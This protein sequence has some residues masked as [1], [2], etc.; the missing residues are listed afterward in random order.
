M[1]NPDAAAPAT[2]EIARADLIPW[3]REEL[4]VGPEAGV[5]EFRRTLLERLEKESWFPS[6]EAQYALETLALRSAEE[7]RAL[8]GV[9]GGSFFWAAEKKLRE[10]VERFAEGF[11]QQSPPQRTI[12]WQ[13]L[14]ERCRTFPTLA[15]RL[16]ALQPG[17]EVVVP[18]TGHDRAVLDLAEHLTQLF[19]LRP[20]ERS[21]RRRTP[22]ERLTA[23]LPQ[24]RDA[25]G[26]LQRQLPLV[27]ALEPGLVNALL[28][29]KKR[30]VSRLGELVP[31]FDTD[32]SARAHDYGGPKKSRKIFNLAPG[33]GVA[34]LRNG[35]VIVVAMFAI[36]VYL[37][38]LSSSKSPPA[39]ST[40][41]AQQSPGAYGRVERDLNAIDREP[42]NRKVAEAL[43]RL[44]AQQQAPRPA[45]FVPRS[46]PMPNPVPNPNRS[47][48]PSFNRPSSRPNPGPAIPARPR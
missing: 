35:W 28:T 26:R 33:Q 30:S 11:F 13:R 18:R 4:Q 19:T 38:F 6:T 15:H 17:L 3:A 47:A 24:W 8:V 29:A 2:L 43:E 31:A 32:G 44:K 40:P 10:E 9:G 5:D 27:A 14:A 45:P 34:I 20:E 21:K 37:N 46:P 7:R 48:N 39:L 36:R 16:R 22:D 25:A 41:R 12:A 23:T 1:R 42:G